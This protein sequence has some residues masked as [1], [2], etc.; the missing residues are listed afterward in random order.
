MIKCSICK[1][2]YSDKDE[3]REHFTKQHD[4]TDVNNIIR[5]LSFLEER[6]KKLEDSR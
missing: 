6:I 3:L 1:Q 4:M 2:D 5:Y